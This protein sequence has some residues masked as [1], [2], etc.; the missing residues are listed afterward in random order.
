MSV[1]LSINPLRKGLIRERAAEPCIFVIFGGTGDLSRRKLLP[2]LYH[3]HLSNL[4]P[5]GF[6]I[7][8]YASSEMDDSGYREMAHQAISKSPTHVPTEGKTWDQFAESLYYVKRSEDTEH[9]L[10]GLKQRVNDLDAAIGTEGNCLFY[11]AIPPFRFAETAEGLGEV[12]LAG[13]N[14]TRGWR[15]LVVEK[16]LGEDL[17]S[18]KAL[19][20]DMQRFFDEEQIYRIDHYLGKET[21]QNIL[22]FRFA[23]EFV[24]PL[25]N[26]E[27]VD[28][29][30]ITV[31]ETL[32][33][34][35]R[36]GYYDSSGALRDI[37]QNHMLQMLSLICMNRPHS[38]DAGAVRDAKIELFR[39]IHPVE[40]SKVGDIALRGQYT[41]GSISGEDVPAYTQ[42]K[43]VAP[44]STTET[45]AVL[46]L[47]I[48]NPRWKGVP[49]YL[50]TG[51]RLAKRVTEIGITLKKPT[52]MFPR[53]G[54]SGQNVLALNI[55]PDE[56]ISMRF[57]A[58]VPG[59][60]YQVQPVRMDFKYGTAFATSVPEAY[61]RLILDAILGDQSLFPR[62]DATE[63]TWAICDPILKAWLANQVP[64]YTYKPGSWGPREAMEFIERD[65]RRWRRL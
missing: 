10:D 24:E 33:L 58:K 53:A 15:K 4:L 16:P 43:D 32:G 7:V 19:N 35:G 23:N 20:R 34:E 38:L 1:D 65:G 48:D 30:Q 26:A 41:S 37:V 29:I 12:S 54:G 64:L 18:A 47:F 17:E 11:L 51:K 21:V 2:A 22:V 44:N 42:E 52:E 3:L 56:G 61:E 36:G 6:A 5:R 13:N 55:Q 9:S 14:N 59:L 25:L 8:G 46:K 39:S 27:H 49:I 31:A 60:A 28:N 45:F 63:A 57:D 62:A 50:R 40:Q